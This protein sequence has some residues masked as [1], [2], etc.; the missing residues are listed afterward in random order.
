MTKKPTNKVDELKEVLQG[1]KQSAPPKAEQEEKQPSQPQDTAE[2]ESIRQKLEAAE[3]TAK[4]NQEQMLR[5]MAEFENYKRRTSK[6]KTEQ[7]KYANEKLVKELLPV[8]DDLERVFEHV[9]E[10]S[11]EEAKNIMQGVGMVQKGL[12]KTLRHFGLHEIHAKGKHFDPNMHEALCCCEALEDCEDN[13][14]TDVHRKGY[15]LGDRV[16]RAAQVTV[17][18]QK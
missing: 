13:T 4:K 14:V 1:R 8:L 5:V 16:I 3:E 12:L 15:K 17:A 10:E 18:K 11:S 2:L 6:E 9:S 7:I